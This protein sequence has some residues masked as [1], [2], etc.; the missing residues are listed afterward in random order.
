MALAIWTVP[1][2]P[3]EVSQTLD[4]GTHD[5]APTVGPRGNSVATTR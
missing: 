2:G 1:D 5:I 4:V 3:S